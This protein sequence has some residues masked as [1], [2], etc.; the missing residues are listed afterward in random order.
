LI[1]GREALSVTC[2]N[3]LLNRTRFCFCCQI[4]RQPDELAAADQRC[5]YGS[6]AVQEAAMY[7]RLLLIA[8][9]G[10]TLS[11]CVPYY[12]EGPGNY[13]SE[14]YTSPAPAYYYGGGPYYSPPARYYSSPRYYEPAPRYYQAPPRV[15]YRV[16]QN[17][18]WDDRHGWGHHD[19]GGRGRRGWDDERSHGRDHDRHGDRN[20]H[21]RGDRNH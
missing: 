7:R 2:F 1:G 11:A 15:E 3:V 20:G 18:G 13:R 6:F 17:R 9:L 21:D 12:D 16:Y 4:F 14:V 10:L 19:E 8:S 5:W